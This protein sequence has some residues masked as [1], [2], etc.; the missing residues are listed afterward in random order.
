MAFAAKINKLLETF[1][2]KYGYFIS[3]Y[4]L[5]VIISC[6]IFAGCLGLGFL[7]LEFE[8]QSEKIYIPRN[9]RAEKDLNTANRY[10]HVKTR[11]LK[12]YSQ[13]LID[14]FV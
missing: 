3:G 12:V 11:Y 2:Y 9:T 8:I 14:S 1:F 5:L 4:P 10:F 6:I 7:K 13:I